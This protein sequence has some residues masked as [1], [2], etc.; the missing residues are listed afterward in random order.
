LLAL[1]TGSKWCER[2]ATSVNCGNASFAGRVGRAL[3]RGRQ[4]AGI[5]FADWHGVCVADKGLD[6]SVEKENTLSGV[7]PIASADAVSS[8]DVKERPDLIGCG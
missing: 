2:G 7:I 1:K 8:E 5:V 4:E 3:W 6:L